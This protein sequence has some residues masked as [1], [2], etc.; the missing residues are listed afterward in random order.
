MDFT[1]IIG[2]VLGLGLVMFGIVFDG[3]GFVMDQLFNFVDYPSMAITFGGAI[4]A[5]VASFPVS[6]F[7]L[8]PQ[9][10]KVIFQGSRYDPQVYIAKIVSLAQD[11]RKKGLL[12]LEDK[13]NQEPDPF[14]RNSV[15]LIV[16]AID[17]AKVKGMLESELDGL[18]DR[19]SH[20]WQFYEKFATYGPAFGMIGTLIGLINMLKN[21]DMS[22]ENGATKM[23]QGMSVALVTTFYG[24]MLAN[25][26]L[27]PI[28]HKLHMRH[29]EEMTCKEMIV[30]GVLAI[31]AG[32]NPTHIEERLNAYVNEKKRISSLNAGKKE[33]SRSKRMKKAS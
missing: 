1:S 22:G 23:A 10:L 15:M 8:I 32:E 33:E 3:S 7:K 21:M 27:V 4:C 11:A 17:P 14:L 18:E 24:S 28:A 31:Q 5:T 2:I 20:G 12:S 25:M 29:D 6:Y 13:A 9:H 19:H 26:V 30:E 16:D